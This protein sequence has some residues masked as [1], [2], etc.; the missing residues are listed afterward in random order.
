M[1]DAKNSTQSSDYNQKR[2]GEKVDKETLDIYDSM[3]SDGLISTEK[4][5]KGK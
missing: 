2:N 4:K 3:T 5:K 1:S